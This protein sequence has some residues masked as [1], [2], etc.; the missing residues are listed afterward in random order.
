MPI[1]WA[2]MGTS[3][4]NLT[5]LQSTRTTL[6]CGRP[7]RR[8]WHLTLEPRPP[9]TMPTC[10]MSRTR[11]PRLT[12]ET[13]TT[14]GRASK[15]TRG[16]M[17]ITK[18]MTSLQ[19]VDQEWNG[20]PWMVSNENRTDRNRRR[21]PSMQRNLERRKPQNSRRGGPEP[22]RSCSKR[23]Q[24]RRCRRARASSEASWDSLSGSLQT[25]RAV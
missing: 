16:S 17:A 10:S 20:P 24:R 22:S 14:R 25:S 21:R 15:Q 13:C 5:F 23:S 19:T 4:H 9:A 3:S 18:S 7:Y 8:P 2:T 12:T 11:D 6:R 1:R